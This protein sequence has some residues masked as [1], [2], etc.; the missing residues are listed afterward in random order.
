MYF[1]KV[2]SSMPTKLE[3]DVSLLGAGAAAPTVVEG[4]GVSVSRG[5]VG[6]YTLTLAEHLG[7]FIRIA[8]PHFRARPPA[9]ATDVKQMTM[10]SLGY[11]ATTRQITIS[12]WSAAGAAEDL[13]A[14]EFLDFGLV[15]KGMTG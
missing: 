8:G 5:A 7:V 3:V 10:T 2:R 14:N 9:A 13:A 1:D 6:V 12:V 4:Q 15:F 11:D